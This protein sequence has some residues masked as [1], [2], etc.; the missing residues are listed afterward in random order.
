MF[1]TQVLRL[2]SAVNA[3]FIEAVASDHADFGHE[4]RKKE[5]SRKPQRKGN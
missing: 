2:P 1:T 3:A 5:I 4:S